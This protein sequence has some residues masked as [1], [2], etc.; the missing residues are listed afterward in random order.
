MASEVRR[1]TDR[2][3]AVLKELDEMA[4]ANIGRSRRIKERIDHLLARLEGGEPLPTIVEGEPQPLIP[5]LITEN[6]EALQDVGSALRK[7]EAAA[8]RA[9]GYTMDEIATLFGV[10]RQRISALLAESG[11]G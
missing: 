5:T 9:H 3:I 7:A 1:T 10:T 2:L 11:T 6:I 8:L 4:E